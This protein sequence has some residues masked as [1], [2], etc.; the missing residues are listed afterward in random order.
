MNTALYR[1][2]RLNLARWIIVLNLFAAIPAWTAMIPG[3]HNTGVDNTGVPLADG[4]SDPHYRLAAGS[5]TTGPT[6]VATSAW[7]WPIAPFGPWLG[8]S[9]TSAWIT[10]AERVGPHAS[11]GV[12]NYRYETSF[13]LT[14]LDPAT[15]IIMGHWATDNAGLDI[16]ING[17][18]TGQA[19]TQQF[20]DLTYFQINHGFVSGRNT[21]TF[22]LNN[23]P[24]EGGESPTGLR[25][26]MTG[27]AEPTKAPPIRLS[28]N[29]LDEGHVQ[30]SW[31][32]TT[33]A[34]GLREASTPCPPLGWTPVTIPAV[35]AGDQMTVALDTHEGS[36]FFRLQP[37]LRRRAIFPKPANTLVESNKVDPGL[38][39]L[40]FH[41]GTHVRLYSGK[42]KFNPR[43]LTTDEQVLLARVDLT[44]EQVRAD[45]QALNSL[46]EQ[47]T[48]R[49][50]ARMFL[51]SEQVLAENKAQG[52]AMSGE[53]LADLDL[54]YYLSL[55]QPDPAA[56]AQLINYL[57]SLRSVEIAYAQPRS[58]S[59]HDDSCNT[60]PGIS[61][62]GAFRH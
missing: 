62:G 45:L 43:N 14:G 56:A 54:Y 60:L 32:L 13:D 55:S 19:N 23:G 25:V 59:D 36:Q 21:L 41:E 50:I 57:N 47:T 26:E 6:F 44:P 22:L 12:A 37:I 2:K 20:S 17:V 8:E 48:N 35:Q 24:G 3:L 15:A 42:L 4:L 7:G 39:I 49:L 18:S 11:A 52:E 9:T 34:L 5:A 1:G 29:R 61:D 10:P 51:E 28:I 33:Q 31:P 30:L 38:I 53:E 27:T 40:K 58:T 46:N 16:L